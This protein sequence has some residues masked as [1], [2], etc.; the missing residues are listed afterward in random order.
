MMVEAPSPNAPSPLHEFQE[1]LRSGKFCYQFST[2]ADRGFFPPRVVCPFTGSTELQ[3][4]EASGLGTVYSTTVVHPR[5]GTPYSVVLVDCDEGFRIMSTVVDVDPD[6]VTI[7]LR[8]SVRI[9]EG[10][11]KVAPFPVFVPF[12]ERR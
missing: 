7:G 8:V 9:N 4:R 1:H 2:R 3:W 12:A 6:E 5:E 11:E 10:S